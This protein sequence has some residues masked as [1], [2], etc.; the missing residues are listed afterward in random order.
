[1]KTE[2]P[3]A[4]S[5][6]RL[7]MGH[8]KVDP[9][10]IVKTS[11]VSKSSKHFCGLNYPE[12]TVGTGKKHANDEH[13]YFRSLDIHFRL[14]RCLESDSDGETTSCPM[15]SESWGY[16][17]IMFYSP[18]T[19]LQISMKDVDKPDSKVCNDD[20]A[21]K[22]ADEMV[23]PNLPLDAV[24]PPLMKDLCNDLLGVS[25]C[26]SPG[27][28]GNTYWSPSN[29]IHPFLMMIST[30]TPMVVAMAMRAML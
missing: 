13:E 24:T 10:L 28:W 19:E 15:K 30:R 17:D 22:D 5:L 20:G 3:W 12:T 7:P 26:V 21:L 18:W 14:T 27:V 4:S 2:L 1:M 8:N 6:I 16:M 25:W 29:R 9:S 23:W 11:H